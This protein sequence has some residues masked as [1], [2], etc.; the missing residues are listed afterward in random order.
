MKIDELARLVA[1]RV[2]FFSKDERYL[3]VDVLILTIVLRSSDRYFEVAPGLW[4]RGDDRPDAGVRSRPPHLPFADAATSPEPHASLD[5]VG[6]PGGRA[7][8]EAG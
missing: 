6:G 7:A 5:V 3:T 1:P 8:V 4:M 2:H